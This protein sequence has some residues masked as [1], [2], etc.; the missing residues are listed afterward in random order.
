VGRTASPGLFFQ[1]WIDRFPLAL[2]YSPSKPPRSG[3]LVA[4]FQLTTNSTGKA[5]VQA[6]MDSGKRLK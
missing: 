6:A 1:H 2:K 3:I 5:L 4:C